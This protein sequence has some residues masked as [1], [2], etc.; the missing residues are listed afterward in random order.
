MTPE[1][2]FFIFII[3]TILY[4]LVKSGHTPTPATGATFVPTTPDGNADNTAVF[5]ITDQSGNPVG[6][7]NVDSNFSISLGPGTFNYSATDANGNTASGSFTVVEG[8]MVQVLVTLRIL[9]GY[10]LTN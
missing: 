2:F 3:F 9:T 1:E 6:G 7:A 5:T 10:S 8:S 4:F